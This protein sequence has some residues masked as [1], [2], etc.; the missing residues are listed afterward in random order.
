MSRYIHVTSFS[1]LVLEIISRESVARYTVE[2]GIHL[3]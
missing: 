3:L 1:F 2:M